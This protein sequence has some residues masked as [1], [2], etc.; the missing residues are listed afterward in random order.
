MTPADRPVVWLRGRVTSPPFSPEARREAGYLL[1]R[2]QRGEKLRMPV[3]RPMPVL[4]VRCHELRIVDDAVTWRLFYR[5]DPDA[6]VIAG[7]CLKKTSA[8]PR[9]V[10]ETCRRRLKEFDDA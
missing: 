9:T 1:R 2:L 4:G 5:I 10:I 3:S 8:T 6:I 7:V